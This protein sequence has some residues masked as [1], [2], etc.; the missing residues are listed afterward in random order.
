MSNN[1]ARPQTIAVVTGSRADYGVL[2]PLLRAIESDCAFQ[3]RLWVTGMHLARQFGYSIDQIAADGFCISEKIDM[4]LASDT[5]GA[6][7]KSVGIGVL[8][9]AEAYARNCPDLLL[10]LG[11]RFELFAA[12]QAALPFKIPVAH[13]SGGETTQGAIDESY[14]HAIT[15]LSHLHFVATESYARRV[16]QMGEEPWRVHVTGEPG[17]DDVATMNFVKI[18]DLESRLGMSLFPKPLICTFHPVTLEHESTGRHIDE[19]LAALKM[20][21]Y[22]VVFTYPNADTAGSVIVEAI[23]NYVLSNP[24]ARAVR[25]LGRLAYCSLMKHAI[26]MVGNSSSGLIEAASFELPVV[27]VGTRQQGR[28]SNRNVLNCECTREAITNAIRMA[29]SEEFRSSV[30][31]I[32]NVYGDGRASERILRV[33]KNVP[34]DRRLIMKRF[35]DISSSEVS[36]ASE[37]CSSTI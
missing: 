22:P 11:D 23:E 10:G 33:M 16:I 25:N 19:L 2:V 18:S 7:A 3:L 17:L 24:N 31:G 12:V 35:H 21:G 32:E 4:L 15:K 30:R 26:A 34:L 8:G 37:Q 1:L 20:S 14:R 36:S 29:V 9:F 6:L 13:I 5:P 28:I 27:N